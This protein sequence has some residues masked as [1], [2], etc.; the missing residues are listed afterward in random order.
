MVAEPC[1][2]MNC[3]ANFFLPKDNLF[4][5]LVNGTFTGYFAEIVKRRADVLTGA[6]VLSHA[7]SLVNAKSISQ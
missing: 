7:R 6:V 2:R 3:K 1:K 5:T 4:G